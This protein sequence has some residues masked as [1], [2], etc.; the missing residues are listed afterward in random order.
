LQAMSSDAELML[1]FGVLHL[2]AIALGA[3]LFVMFLRSETTDHQQPP[4]DEDGGGGGN[5]RV[6]VRP[7]VS[8]SG[9]LPLPDAVAPLVRLR[10]HERLADLRPRP[11]RRPLRDPAPRRRPIRRD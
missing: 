6:S 8:P 2:V 10:S 9:G 11:A 4:E 3:V 7:K 1:I 5:D